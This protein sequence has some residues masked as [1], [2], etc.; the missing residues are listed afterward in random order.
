LDVVSHPVAVGLTLFNEN[1][2]SA[3]INYSKS[4]TGSTDIVSA[5]L[6]FGESVF[7]I[8]INRLAP[9]SKKS[10]HILF[11]DGELFYW[12]EKALYKFDKKKKEYLKKKES[13]QEPL[14][15]ECRQFIS[16]I[17]ENTEIRKNRDFGYRVNKV[18]KQVQNKV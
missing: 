4:V 1:P 9:I 13:N 3:N 12:S 7:S 8:D 2:R 17:N 5:D 14:Q 15:T 10:L 18:I 11:E 6:Q 16:I